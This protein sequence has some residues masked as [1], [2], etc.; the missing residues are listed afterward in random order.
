MPD[1]AFWRRLDAPG[2]DAA[3]ITRTDDGWLLRG[4][5]VFLHESGPACLNY[6]VSLDPGWRA[7]RGRVQGF[8]SET[9][10]DQLIERNHEGWNLN[11]AKAEGLDHLIDLD[12]GFTP[13]TNLPQ[14]CRLALRPGEAAEAPAAWL[15]AGASTLVE[16]PQRYERRDEN[17]YWYQA[18]S[19]GYEAVL[20]IAGNGFVAVYPELWEMERG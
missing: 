13:A 12:F 11:G 8:L 10:V 20:K 4:A 6:S 1:F 15:A 3:Q 9:E 19:F 5:A 2:H 14:L 7:V 18:P 16:L 17:S